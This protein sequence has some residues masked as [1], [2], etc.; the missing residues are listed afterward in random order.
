M[1]ETFALLAK[2]GGGYVA[3]CCIHLH[4]SC[5]LLNSAERN[6][7]HQTKPGGGLREG[8]LSAWLDLRF[9]QNEISRCSLNTAQ[10][11][12]RWGVTV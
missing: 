7:E 10:V 1:L 5:Y 11:Q 12:G 8:R 9:S 2:P 3:V 4:M 6:V